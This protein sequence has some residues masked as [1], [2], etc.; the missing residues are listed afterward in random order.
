MP[1]ARLAALIGFVALLGACAGS[2]DVASVSTTDMGSL[3]TTYDILASSATH[4][5]VG[6]TTKADSKDKEKDKAKPAQARKRAS[7]AEIA[8][9]LIS[10]HRRAH[11][12]GPVKVDPHL[13]APAMHQAQVVAQTGWLFHGEFASR[14]A[15]YGI[16]GQA[17]ENLSAGL[18][19]VEQ[20]IA[21][22]KASPGH[23]SNLLLP[24]ITRIGLARVDRPGSTHGRYWALVLAR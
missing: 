9:A 18:W 13:N 3:S 22:W 8:A 20:V 2:R 4:E 11:G 12:L 24:A 19:T 1:L 17:A 5:I 10:Q 16:R 7:D 14:M 21:Q 23:N 15:S 6:S